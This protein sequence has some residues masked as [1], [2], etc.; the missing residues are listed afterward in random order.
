MVGPRLQLKLSQQLT[1]APQLQQA[2]RLL[3]LSRLELRDYIQEMLDAN[4]LLER[5]EGDAGTEGETGSGDTGEELGR[6]TENREV[7]NLEY[8]ADY[9]DH[10]AQDPAHDSGGGY[11]GDGD[12]IADSAADADGESLR[13]HLLW[14]INLSPLSAKDLLIAQAV[15]YALDGDGFL[16]EDVDELQAM[17][18]REMDVS[19]GEIMA[20][21]HRIQRMEPVGAATRGP[22]ECL[23]V[24]LQAQPQD[25][26][27]RDL[28][29]RIVRD[30]LDLL[31]AG[32]RDELKRATRATDS[33]LNQAIDLIQ[34]MEPRPGARYDNRRDE[35]IAPDVYVRQINDRWVVSLSPDNQ[36]N[37]KLNGY[38]LGLMRSAKGSDAKYLRGRLQEARWLLTSLELRNRT[39]VNVADA[40]VTKQQGFLQHGEM[41][42]KPLILRDVA[43]A[44]G[45][46]E[47]TVSRATTRKYML[48]PRG[49]YEL[50]YF[51]SSH[52]ATRRGG[53][54][55]ATAVKA[56]LAQLLE[57]EDA[58]RP[59][60]DQAYADLLGRQ[61][62]RIARRTVAKY[63][64][65]LGIGSSAERRRAA[66][67]ARML[68]GR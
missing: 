29:S 28:A 22:R 42:M 26:P 11:A 60:S 49:L 24:Q 31:V 33:T 9:E 56:R 5:S 61:G 25:T 53:S 64:E 52:V 63:R 68:A 62:I 37:L 58:D 66:R 19:S 10:W 4:P 2:I 51:F 34:S 8:D 59:L 16:Q 17:L 36:P 47:S 6:E 48:T 1:L 41:E 44:V 54:I 30:Y 39:L 27:G 45:V 14:Q 50:K 21:L 18:A 46:H 40:I 7:E 55:S 57:Q 65:A 35:F 13:D 15:V 3:Q 20:V 43:E 32:Q 12:L 38:Y 67:R 23:L